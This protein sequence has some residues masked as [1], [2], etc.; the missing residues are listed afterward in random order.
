MKFKEER[1]SVKTLMEEPFPSVLIFNHTEVAVI[2]G[3]YVIRNKMN[4]K[5][6]IGQSSD[7]ES[8]W[9]HHVNDL[10]SNCH[11]NQKLQNAWNKYGKDNFIF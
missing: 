2:V 3:I 4:G 7:I 8:R 10:K 9:K 11:H 6:Y 1:S 5:C